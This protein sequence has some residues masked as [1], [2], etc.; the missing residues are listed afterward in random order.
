MAA[1]LARNPTLK[2]LLDLPARVAALED[3][4]RKLEGGPAPAPALRPGAKPCQFCG[5]PLKLTAEVDH[6]QLGAVG[7]KVRTY[8]CE[9]CGKVIT[10]DYDPRKDKP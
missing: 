8:E 4:V 10:R 7:L 3:K 9:S 5:G 2:A 6:P 1:L